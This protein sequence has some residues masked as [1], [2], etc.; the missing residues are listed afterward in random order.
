[1]DGSVGS[2]ERIFS[3][4]LSIYDYNNKTRKDEKKGEKRGGV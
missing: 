3:L 2:S 4:S 1:M